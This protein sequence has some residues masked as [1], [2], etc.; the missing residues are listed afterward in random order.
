MKGYYIAYALMMVILMGIFVT[1][2]ALPILIVSGI[3]LI[4]V[5][6]KK[7]FFLN[8]L[9]QAIYQNY[10]EETEDVSS[11]GKIIDVEFHEVK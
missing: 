7:W 5:V 10:A 4:Y 2:L 9:R 8:K 3:Y 11:A 6:I 1:Y